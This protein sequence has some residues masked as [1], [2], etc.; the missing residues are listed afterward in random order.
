MFRD[1]CGS[2]I[3]A[4]SATF[5]KRPEASFEGRIKLQRPGEIGKTGS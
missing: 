4:P 3:Y 2:V 1:A 5:P